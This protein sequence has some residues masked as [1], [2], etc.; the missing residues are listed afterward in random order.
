MGQWS[1]HQPQAR[2]WRLQ[3]VLHQLVL[4]QTV[5][6]QMVLHQMVLHQMVLHQMV[7]PSQQAQLNRVVHP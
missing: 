3:L 4:H 1:T 6:H 5:L 2:C 7:Q